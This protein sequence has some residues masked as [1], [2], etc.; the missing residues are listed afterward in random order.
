MKAG[1]YKNTISELNTAML[2]PENLE[3]G[4]SLNDD[5]NAMIY[6]FMGQAYK[7][8]KNTEKAKECYQKSIDAKNAPSW[9]DLIYFQAKAYEELGNVTKAKEFF[10]ELIENGTTL[11]EKGKGISG[12]GVG[13][14]TSNKVSMSEAYYLQALGNKGLGNDELAKELFENALEV[15]KN[16]LWAMTLSK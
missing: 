11:L 3:V 2:Y 6:Y 8:M 13:E 7:G 14:R 12:I 16:N 15:Y 1:D 4:K 9:P 10:S 5:R